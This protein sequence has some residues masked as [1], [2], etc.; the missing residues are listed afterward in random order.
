MRAASVGLV[1]LMAIGCGGAGTTPGQPRHDGR[2]GIVGAG[3][4][5]RRHAGRAT[6]RIGRHRQ[7]SSVALARVDGHTIAFVADDDRDALIS[8]DVDAGAARAVT[9]L[10]AAP[11]Q[12]MV[13]ADGR[14]AVTLRD[15]NRLAIYEPT[16]ADAP[17][18]A[19]CS[20]A[21]PVEPFGLA[22]TPDDR[23]VLVTSAWARRVTA[24]D[25]E[26]LKERYSRQVPREPRNLVV[27]DEGRRAFVAH[28]VGGSLSVVDLDPDA[29]DLREIDLRVPKADRRGPRFSCQGFALAKSIAM[30]DAIDAAPL[31]D[32]EK[33][34]L[35]LDTK[36]DKR[37]EVPRGRIFA[38]RVTIDPGEP[39]QRSSGY[40]NSRSQEIEAPIVNVV[41]AAAERNL[42]TALL[43]RDR[44]DAPK[45][46]CL[47]PR[48]AAISA[49]SGGLLVTCMG[50]DALVELD[51][52]GVDPARLERRRWQV[53][54]GP[55][56]VAVDDAHARAV[57]WG[58]FARQLA[59]VDLASASPDDAIHLVVAPT[60]GVGKLSAAAV[61][62]RRL[63][64]KTDDARISRDGR[65]CASCH[66]D[67]R[68]D[69][70]TWSTPVGP[71]QTI[72]LAGRIAGTAPFSWL[73][74]H[75]SLQVHLTNTFQRLGGTGLPQGTGMEMDALIAYLHEMP[76]PSMS[77]ALSDAEESALAARGQRIFHAADTRC[78]GCHV[79]GRQTDTRVH[80]IGTKVRGD[81]EESFD[82]PS[83]AFVG[84]TAP[85]FHDGRFPTLMDLLMTTESKMGHSMHLSH[86]DARALSAYLETL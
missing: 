46:E 2:T 17:L 54:E 86:A 44:L 55:T 47:L 78:A 5:G 3:P 30:S 36:P 65:A 31:E 10:G 57:V 50:N 32:P 45:G 84:G 66:P 80:D 56:G 1:A 51:P 48:A 67:G 40:G 72:M 62:G 16:T 71:R 28:V 75:E 25:A 23:T 4:C 33:P 29:R 21:T 69:Q 12:V 22:G 63:F 7:G 24:Y 64:H 6:E 73:G 85:Y 70:L 61:W 83:L 82:T 20:V 9:P 18:E 68:E 37:I 15:K 42:T 79:G 19:L 11:A 81:T 77:G 38:P 53:P 34:P 58:Q 59:V 26:S 35:H 8:V 60:V 49:A 76:A 74:A 27:D 52:R 41:D 39:S 14:V 13:L 43:R